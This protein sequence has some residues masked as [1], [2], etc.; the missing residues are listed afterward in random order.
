LNTT[1]LKV[2]TMDLFAAKGQQGS[3]WAW[4][5]IGALLLFLLTGVLLVTSLNSVKAQSSEAGSILSAPISHP[6]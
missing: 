6:S 4:A 1:R 3:R 2:F 5:R